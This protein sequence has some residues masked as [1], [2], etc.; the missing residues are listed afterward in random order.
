M[1]KQVQ[2]SISSLSNGKYALHARCSRV[3][4]EENVQT[5]YRNSKITDTLDE[6]LEEAKKV[7]DNG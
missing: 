4:E 3:D 2:I 1:E 6:A 7:E 5:T